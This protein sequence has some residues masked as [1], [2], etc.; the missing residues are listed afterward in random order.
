M[1]TEWPAYVGVRFEKSFVDI[2]SDVG[3]V[4][5]DSHTL[6]FGYYQSIVNCILE[7]CRRCRFE[8]EEHI[9]SSSFAASES[10]KSFFL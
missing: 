2:F 1:E 5:F 6:L 3:P 9:S 7:L 4:F 10:L 8:Q